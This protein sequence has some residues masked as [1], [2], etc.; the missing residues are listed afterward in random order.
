M[1]SDNSKKSCRSRKSHSENHR[2]NEVL[3]YRYTFTRLN[4]NFT[5]HF[6]LQLHIKHYFPSSR[7]TRL[8]LSNRRSKTDAK[9]DSGSIW[10]KH[11]KRTS[12]FKPLPSGIWKGLLKVRS[13]E[14]DEGSWVCSSRRRIIRVWFGAFMVLLVCTFWRSPAESQFHEKGS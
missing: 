9:A 8:Y 6:S 14:W 1:N 11:L 5:F 4:W 7:Q 12:F 2:I 13:E 10:G 3:L